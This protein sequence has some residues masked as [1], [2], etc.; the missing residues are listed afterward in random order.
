MPETVRS[1]SWEAPEHQHVDKT[2]DW[3]WALGIIAIAAAGA[4]IIFGNMLFGIVIL[5]AAGTM[6]LVAHRQ[7]NLVQYEVSQRG[8]RVGNTF[9]PYGTLESFCLDE[10]CYEGPQLIVKSQHL[11]VPLIIL[12]VPEDHVHDIDDILSLRIREEH[13]QEPLA[14]RL[15]EFFGF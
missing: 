10:E 15:L 4:S 13:L 9:Y 3:Y 14:H 5:L 1:I 12:P 11:F 8:I 2:S 7:P 6:I